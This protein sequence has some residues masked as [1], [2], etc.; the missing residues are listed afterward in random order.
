[1]WSD[2]TCN[3]K[4]I[5]KSILIHINNHILFSFHFQGLAFTHEERQILGVHGLLPASIK[6]L[7]EQ[8]EHCTIL[9]DRYENDL[10]KYIYLNGLYVSFILLSARFHQNRTNYSIFYFSIGS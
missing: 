10:D 5:R 2:I 1:M 6:S 3:H 8:V 9:L 7:D 4:F